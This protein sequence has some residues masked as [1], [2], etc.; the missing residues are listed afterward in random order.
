MI[1][2]WSESDCRTDASSSWRGVAWKQK[3]CEFYDKNLYNRRLLTVVLW[4]DLGNSK[5]ALRYKRKKSLFESQIHNCLS[6]PSKI[7]L[8]HSQGLW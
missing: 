1:Y 2:F 8:D 5:I 4:L 6:Q 3:S 7:C